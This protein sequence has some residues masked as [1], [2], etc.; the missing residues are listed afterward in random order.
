MLVICLFGAATRCRRN[1]SLL[2]RARSGYC[3]ESLSPRSAERA[4]S[5]RVAVWSQA[6]NRWSRR[7]EGAAARPGVRRGAQRSRPTGG[8]PRHWVGRRE[9]LGRRRQ[10]ERVQEVLLLEAKI[11]VDALPLTSERGHRRCERVVCR[12]DDP[13]H[14]VTGPRDQR[15]QGARPGNKVF[16][17]FSPGHVCRQEYPTS[18]YSHVAPLRSG[19]RGDLSSRQRASVA[20]FPQ[21]RSSRR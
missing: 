5:I 4:G 19:Q 3:G 17:D 16:R 1:H 13:V 21:V 20:A 11:K 8:D 15:R 12:R 14:R 6:E 9:R 18:V 10:H 2:R 7:P